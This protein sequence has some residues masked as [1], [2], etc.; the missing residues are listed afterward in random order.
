MPNDIPDDLSPIEDQTPSLPGDTVPSDLAPMDWRSEA[1]QEIDR[2]GL[3]PLDPQGT[4]QMQAIY[5]AYRKNY[6]TPDEQAKPDYGQVLEARRQAGMQS[7]NQAHGFWASNAI[8]TMHPAANL[9]ARAENVL[10]P[11]V[12]LVS[13]SAAQNMEESAQTLQETR[14]ANSLTSLPGQILGS[15]PTFANPALAAVSG[16]NEA[17]TGDEEAKA[18]GQQISGGQEILHVIGKGTIDAALSKVFVQQP[19]AASIA[20]SLEQK[21]AQLLEQYGSEWLAKYGAKGLVGALANEVGNEATNALYQ[22]PFGTNAGQSALLGAALPIAHEAATEA[23]GGLH[24]DPEETPIPEIT[25]HTAE[26]QNIPSDLTP[27][28]E[29]PQETAP[30]EDR[31]QVSEEPPDN[32]ERRMPHTPGDQDYTLSDEVADKILSAKTDEE[33]QAIAQQHLDEVAP[34]DDRRQVSDEPPGGVERRMPHTPGDENY[35]ESDQVADQVLAAKTDEEAQSIAAQHLDKVA[36]LPEPIGKPAEMAP[37]TP[38]ESPVNPLLSNMRKGAVA[39]PDLSGPLE[40]GRQLVR[41]VG[42]LTGSDIGLDKTGVKTANDIRGLYGEQGRQAAILEQQTA[43]HIKAAEGLPKD[44]ATRLVDEI[45]SGQPLSDPRFQQFADAHRQLAASYGQRADALGWD[46]SKW[47]PDWIGRT[48]EFPDENG[49]FQGQQGYSAK[50]AG[51]ENYLKGRTFDNYSDALAAVE[52]AGGRPKYDNPIKMALAKD[53][54]VSNSLLAHEQF[55]KF[56]DQGMVREVTKG[57][58]LQPGEDLISDPMRWTHSD[59]KQFAAKQDVADLLNHVSSENTGSKIADVVTNGN[60][61]ATRVQMAVNLRHYLTES[62]GASGELYGQAFKD[63]LR[64]RFKQAG[65]EVIEATPGIGTL[66]SL[67]RGRNLNPESETATAIAKGGGDTGPGRSLLQDSDWKSAKEA[68]ANGE[69]LKAA[70]HVVGNVL[71]VANKL[72][73]EKYIPTLRKGVASMIAESE[74]SNAQDKGI[75]VNSDEFRDTM[76]KHVLTM[77]NMLGVEDSRI[78]FQNKTAAT[79]G[80]MLFGLPNWF[81]GKAR[82]SV[83]AVKG[84]APLFEGKNADPATYG[85]LGAIATTGVVGT[86]LYAAF[87]GGKMPTSWNDLRHVPTPWKGDDGKPIRLTIPYPWEMISDVATG[88]RTPAETIASRLAPLLKFAQQ[89]YSGKNFQGG[90]TRETWGDV[91]KS[92]KDTI[93]TPYAVSEF[94]KEGLPAPVKGLAMAGITPSAQKFSQSPAERMAYDLIAQKQP[95]GPK[96]DEEMTQATLEH[97]I[98]AALKK[99]DYTPLEDAVDQE[100]LTPS[101]ARVLVKKAQEP[102]GLEGLVSSHELTHQDLMAIWQKASSSERTVIHD[103]LYSRIAKETS[104]TGAMKERFLNQLDAQ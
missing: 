31:R 64:G 18:A 29:I 50:L 70:S 95:I 57:S 55:Q 12:G 4:S 71:G 59:V 24:A 63:L 38:E 79:V 61:L 20:G 32:V 86:A 77:S 28:T 22:K 6:G 81:L 48:F 7:Q 80:R 54:E 72:L 40:Y 41:E 66:A 104:L 53:V 9:F 84:L 102:L 30:I 58:P 89:M 83:D 17:Y 37:A 1:K 33:A 88:D 35:T 47:T 19:G 103:T 34:L 85:A 65:R 100:K 45:G 94:S 87:N 68:W 26:T 5:D 96:S 73:F 91:A 25:S 21:A 11:A 39:L 3:S 56:V 27:V 16:A 60:R 13:P 44:Q 98:T 74:L 42:R 90:A 23:I 92:L 99:D 69:G 101:Q 49:K 93:G 62:L 97:S 2:Q 67:M 43:P 51:S 82:F 46:T 15:L 10:A 78:H 75:D 8:E 76:N 52:K 36:P 14:G